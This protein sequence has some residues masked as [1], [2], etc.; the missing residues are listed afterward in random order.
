MIRKAF[1]WVGAHRKLS[2]LLFLLLLF[3]LLNVLAYVHAHAMTHFAEAGERTASPEKLSFLGKVGVL[4]TGVR[5]PRPSG[6]GTPADRGLAFEVHH[7]DV[8]DGTRLE[9]WHVPHPRARGLVLLFHGYASDKAGVL[10]EIAAFHELGYAT[11]A[12]D[13]RGS[14]GSSG[15]VTTIGV[16]EADDVTAACAHARAKGLG[17]PVILFGKSMGAAAVLRAVSALGLCPDALVLECPF[18]R[19]L[20]TVEARFEAMGVPAFP[21]ARLLVFWGGVQHGFDGFAH[22]PADY[23]RAVRC[24]ALF[25]HGERD[26]RVR[27]A[28]VEAVAAAVRGP[29][30]TVIFTGLGH[31][32]YVSARPRQWREAVSGF[33]AARLVPVEK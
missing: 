22:N 20:S 26:P 6:E 29:H 15:N 27:V 5:V 4:F 32:S 2:A 8:A 17:G 9:A 21:A 30:Q 25:L 7:T 10:P 14:G 24:P 28:Q 12:V 33:L 31:E 1:R 11:L 3:V 23:A 16:R 13:F 18:D 19:L